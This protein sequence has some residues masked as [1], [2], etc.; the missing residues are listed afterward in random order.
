[1]SATNDLTVNHDGGHT[2]IYDLDGDG[3]ISPEEAALRDMANAIYSM[4]NEEGD[5]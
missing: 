3:E 2:D 5:I 1:V 4:I